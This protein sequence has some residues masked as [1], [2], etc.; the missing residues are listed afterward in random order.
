[1]KTLIVANR[2]SP[3]TLDAL[4]Q[5]AAYLDSQGLEHFEIDVSD[6]PGPADTFG[7][8]AAALQ[9]K[10]GTGYGLIITLGGDGTLLHS[11]RLA[12]VLH[13]PIMGIHFGHMGFLTNTAEEGTIPL[14]AD[15]LAGEIIHETRMN[16]HVKVECEGDEEEPPQTPREF[17]AF[18]EIAIARGAL[19]HIVD[20]EFSVS[21]DRIARMRGDG[22]IVSTATGSTAYALSAGGP[23]VGPS[24]RGMI[25]VPLAPHS[26]YSRAIVTEHHDVV[27]V[28]L[29]GHSA[30]E[31]SL[32]ADGD[33]LEFER[34]V[35]TVVVTVGREP[36]VLLTRRQESFYKQIGHTFFQ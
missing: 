28:T 7:E 5:I 25:A 13:A 16:L 26:L 3:K 35:S 15:A 27:E 10:Y 21:G 4:F 8:R 11:A 23:L 36:T 20:F 34:P 9:Q 19:G 12:D 24:H 18:N 30:A 33:A 2:K 29:E 32:F 31:V 6:L 14:I 1:M 17:F 22:L